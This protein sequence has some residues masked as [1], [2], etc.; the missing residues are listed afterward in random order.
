MVNT[1]LIWVL[2][3]IIACYISLS[4]SN[5]ECH[6]EVEEKDEVNYEDGIFFW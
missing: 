6:L 4:L 1:D 3:K 5:S 2:Y